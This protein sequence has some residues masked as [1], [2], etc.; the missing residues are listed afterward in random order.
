MR[1][2]KHRTP[3]CMRLAIRVIIFL[4]TNLVAQTQSLPSQPAIE[5]PTSIASYYGVDSQSLAPASSS[6][7]GKVL[8]PNDGYHSITP[9]QRF[10]WF[11]TSTV[12]QSHLAGVAFTS[13]CG[14]AAKR[15]AEYGPHWKG[16]ANRFGSGTAGSAVGNT[17]EAGAGFFLREDPRYFRAAQLTFRA[18]VGNVMQRTFSTRSGNG[19]LVPAYARFLGIVGGNFLSNTWRVPSEANSRDALLRSS[20][21]FAGRMMANAFHEFWP[22]LKKY[23]FRTRVP[24]A[25]IQFQNAH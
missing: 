17:L 23:A 3:L 15:P 24:G 14:A 11:V 12:G 16:Y 8:L 9:S 25:A 7:S 5:E 19:R 21:G 13:A 22:D 2:E 18:R 6:V 1:F 10:Q 4:A 20:E